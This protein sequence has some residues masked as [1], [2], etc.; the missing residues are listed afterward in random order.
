MK[1]TQQKL[2]GWGYHTVR[3]S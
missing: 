1:L 3:M 2:D